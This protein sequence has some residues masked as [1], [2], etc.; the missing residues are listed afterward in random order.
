MAGENLGRGGKSQQLGLDRLDEEFVIAAREIG[1]PNGAAKES[2]TGDD[3]AL[4]GQVKADAAGRMAG[5]EKDAHLVAQAIEGLAGGEAP[6]NGEG[7]GLRDA[8]P[9]GLHGE[10]VVGGLVLGVHGDGGTE[11]ALQLGDGTDVV[12]VGVGEQDLFDVEAGIFQ[13]RQDF[14]K[15]VARIDDDG[16]A[17]AAQNGAIAL[18]N[19]QWEKIMPQRRVCSHSSV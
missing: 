6:V 19:A 2:I 3:F 11:M 12:N 8:G 18:E 5:G 7:F 1:A 17:V 13:E 9:L 16:A 10:E 15:L 14:G 4:L